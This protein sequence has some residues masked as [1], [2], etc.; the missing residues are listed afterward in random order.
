MAHFEVKKGNY[1]FFN[2]HIANRE[3]MKFQTLYQKMNKMQSNESRVLK[4]MKFKA[5]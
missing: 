1:F 5:F 4:K 3:H 2:W